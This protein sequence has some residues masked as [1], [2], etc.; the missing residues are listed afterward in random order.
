MTT[1]NGTRRR[2]LIV[3]GTI[4]MVV[5]VV[6]A[7]LLWFAAGERLQSAVDSL[8]PAPVGCDTTL[9]FDQTGIYYVYAETSGAVGNLDGDCENDD[10][11]YRDGGTDLDIALFDGGDEV[12]LD[13]S[14]DITYDAGSS[15]GRSLYA[16]DISDT[17]DYVLRVEGSD[18][19]VVARVGGDPNGGVGALRAGAVASVI[20]GLLAGALFLLLGMRRQDA[21]RP[22]DTP[23]PPTAWR[24]APSLGDV[25]VPLGPP[26]NHGPGTTMP[27]PPVSPPAAPAPPGD[28]RPPTSDWGPPRS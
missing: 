15:E 9:Q 2:P 6:A 19:D 13:E 16:I 26:L 1:E 11:E 27:Q 21:P 17:G 12:D 8:A 7:G 5:G 28:R 10:R 20:V 4:V 25:P 22:D 18:D 3:V 23:G 14:G 24:P